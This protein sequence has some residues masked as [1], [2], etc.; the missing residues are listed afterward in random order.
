MDVPWSFKG[1]KRGY[2]MRG[3]LICSVAA[4][5]LVMPAGSACAAEPGSAAPV[6]ELSALDGGYTESSSLF[7]SNDLSFLVFWDSQCEHCVESLERADLFHREYGGGGITVTGINTDLG[8]V[9][10]VRSVVE[11]AGVSFPQLLDPGGSAADLYGVPFGS[12]ALFLVDSRGII[13][14]GEVDPEGD[15]YT[16]M[17]EMLS[18]PA[19]LAAAAPQETGAGLVFRGDGRIRFLGID[20]KRSDPVGPY[21]EVDSSGNHAQ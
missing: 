13:V 8:P 10:Q 3:F 2:A 1:L 4:A 20:T 19:P 7:E 12:L 5:V 16:I 9:L 6:F 11:R 14:V 15:I 17:T 18:A 21:G